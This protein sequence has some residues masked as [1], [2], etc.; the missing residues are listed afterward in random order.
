M[1]IFTSAISVLIIGNWVLT[2]L[3]N[4]IEILQGYLL[5]YMIVYN[6]EWINANENRLGLP[7]NGL[8]RSRQ[9]L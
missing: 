1:H 2:T 4:L 9:K 7:L 3:I 5:F 6:L 8:I